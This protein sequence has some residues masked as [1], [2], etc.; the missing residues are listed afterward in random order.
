[1]LRDKSELIEDMRI[2]ANQMRWET[3]VIEV[4]AIGD[5]Q[6]LVCQKVGWRRHSSSS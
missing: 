5:Q 4:D 6:L 1:M 2:L 3:R